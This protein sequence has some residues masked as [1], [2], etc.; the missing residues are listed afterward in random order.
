MK[1]LITLKDVTIRLGDRF[2]LPHSNWE[3]KAG[4][5]WAVLGPNGAGKSTL[6]RA[7]TGDVPCV[8]GRLTYHG[9]LA[10][11]R[12]IGC[13]SWEEQERLLARDQ[14]MD[15]ARDFAHRSDGFETARKAILSGIETDAAD[16]SGFAKISPWPVSG[17]CWIAPSVSCPRGR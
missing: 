14:A 3:I 9:P 16:S 6:V 8:R 10:V 7:L 13:V 12:T 17:M 4:E 15:A 5:N 1:N 2:L 11:R